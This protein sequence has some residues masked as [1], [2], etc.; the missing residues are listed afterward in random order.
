[1]T[2]SATLLRYR[3]SVVPFAWPANA[4]VFIYETANFGE[5]LASG[6]RPNGT[7]LA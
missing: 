6:R 4:G 5:E 3:G 2:S 7:P 1:M